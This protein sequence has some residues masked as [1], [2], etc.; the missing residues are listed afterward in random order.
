MAF[1]GVESGQRQLPNRAKSK[2][3]CPSIHPQ[4]ACDDASWLLATINN[5]QDAAHCLHRYVTGAKMPLTRAAIAAQTQLESEMAVNIALPASPV[6]S[7]EGFRRSVNGSKRILSGPREPIVIAQDPTE[8]PPRPGSPAIDLRASILKPKG[9]AKQLLAKE[10]GMR[11]TSNK[12]NMQPT[13]VAQQPALP[14][15]NAVRDGRI[16]E[17]L[18]ALP[19]AAKAEQTTVAND[20]EKRGA[21]I[22][23]NTDVPIPEATAAAES[24]SDAVPTSASQANAGTRRVSSKARPSMTQGTRRVSS[25]RP[26]RQSTARLSSAQVDIPHS[27]PRPM[28]IT[29]PTP[30]AAPKST[31]P[32]TRPTFQLPGEAVA[33]KLKAAKEERLRKD[34]E[35]P[36][37]KAPF[38]ARPAPRMSLDHGLVRQTKASLAREALMNP[39]RRSSSAVVQPSRLS[40]MHAVDRRASSSGS[41]A[42]HRSSR[43]SSVAPP[44][45]SLLSAS[46]S[47]PRPSLSGTGAST[48][49]DKGKEVFRRAAQNLAEQER[50]RKEKEE[51]AKKAR[52]EA[53]ERGRLASK[54]WAERQRLK[55][56]AAKQTEQGR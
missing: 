41:V 31:R 55:A 12:E 32:P 39:D 54:E 34:E 20:Q 19:S 27:K 33:A 3:F 11:S 22:L 6:P 45:P 13:S 17:A 15:D 53:A 29:Y 46:V 35:P 37:K 2:Q 21:D 1:V 4:P 40:M 48:R 7:I 49:T 52:A 38:K 26:L 36:F 14:V 25:A 10:R 23:A 16:G 30:P 9:Q 44:R 51:A 47:G 24:Q 42:D 18:P 43:S 50:K 8:E 28:H 5:Y 56:L